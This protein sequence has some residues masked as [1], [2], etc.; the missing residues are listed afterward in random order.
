ML[1]LI[2]PW[3]FQLLTWTSLLKTFSLVSSAHMAASCA[4]HMSCVVPSFL[5]SVFVC[6][7]QNVDK[8]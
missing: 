7:W 5:Q 4:L 3:V 8:Y 1:K 6:H 2:L